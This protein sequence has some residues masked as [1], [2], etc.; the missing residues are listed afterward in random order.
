MLQL[1]I[2]KDERVKKKATSLS[3]FIIFYMA[4]KL[5]FFRKISLKESLT[6]LL[7]RKKSIQNQINFALNDK[8]AH[9]LQTVLFWW[10][11]FKGLSRII[12]IV[13]F[14]IYIYRLFQAFMMYGWSFWKQ[15]ITL[16]YEAISEKDLNGLKFM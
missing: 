2:K 3:H 5:K 16:C 8:A 9:A 11:H 13:I 10:K 6:N 1:P 12:A 4:L 15:T 7:K 14:Y